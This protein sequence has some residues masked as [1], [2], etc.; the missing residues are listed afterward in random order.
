MSHASPLAAFGR[1]AVAWL[2]RVPID[3]PVDRRNAPALQVLLLFLGVEIPLNKAYHLLSGHVTMTGTRLVVDLGT[4]A[5]I[6]GAACVAVWMIRRGLLRE[7][8]GAFLAILMACAVA[9]NLAF[10]YQL[11]AFDP[12]PMIMLTIAALVIGRRALWIVYACIPLVFAL[13]MASPWGLD[14][15]RSGHAFQ[16]LPS[17]AFS[18]LMIALVL[19]RTV[20]ALRETLRRAQRSAQ[21]LREQ[22]VEREH[23]RERMLHLQKIESVGHLASGVS[24]DFNNVLGAIVGYTAERHRLDEFDFDP[25]PDARRLGA[26]LEGIELAAQRGIALSRKLLSF[27]RRELAVPARFDAARALAELAPML[28]QLFDGR[29]EVVLELPPAPVPVFLDRSQLDL[30]MLNFAA[31]ARDAMPGGGRF[32]IALRAIGDGR[33]R[34]VVA[35]TG[36]GMTPEVMRQAFEPFFT[37]KPAGEGTGLGLA[38]AWEMACEAGGTLHVDSA[39]GSGTRFTLDLPQVD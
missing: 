35:D 32:E 13:G 29:V 10:G 5:A 3:D 38:V 21:Q 28:R 30:V 4:D 37:T 1:R 36:H 20:A 25:E 14:A 34:I 16:N 9:A 6:A 18:Y 2:R 26:A 12:Y 15:G 39:P 23:M 31:N 11:Q 19:D 27:S 24:H 8:V 33:A 7:G 17:L 22:M